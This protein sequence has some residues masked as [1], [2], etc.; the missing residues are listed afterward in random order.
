MAGK[1]GFMVYFEDWLPLE[2]LD[3]TQFRAVFRAATNYAQTGE[4]D[5]ISDPVANM[6]FM[7]LRSKIERDGSKYSSIIEKRREAGRKSARIRQ[8]NE[9]MPTHANKC[10]QMPTHANTCQQIQPTVIPTVTPTVIPTVTASLSDARA[11]AEEPERENETP[12]AYPSVAEVEAYA[13]EIGL[14]VDAQ[15]FVGINRAS[16]WLDGEGRP[17]R[18]WKLWLQGYA[19]RNK[20]A[21]DGTDKAGAFLAMAKEGDET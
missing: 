8:Q 7:M 6:V 4:T 15:R 11:R 9:Q 19:V 12:V 10:Q 20:A 3:D 13:Q 14:A 16:G 1:P 5:A 17:I 2:A 21:P 18:N